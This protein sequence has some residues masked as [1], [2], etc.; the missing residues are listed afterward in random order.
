VRRDGGSDP[1][2]VLVPVTGTQR[3]D[4]PAELPARGARLG[5][6]V[7]EGLLEARGSNMQIIRAGSSLS[8]RRR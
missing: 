3:T 7:E 4:H 1:R 8:T 2:E 6:D 5:H